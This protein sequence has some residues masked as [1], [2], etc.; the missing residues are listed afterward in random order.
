MEWLMKKV[1]IKTRLVIL[2]GGLVFIV[3][4]LL[5]G[6]IPLSS[7]DLPAMEKNVDMLIE[8]LNGEDWVSLYE[9]ALEHYP[10]SELAHPFRHTYTV[11]VDNE[12]PV[13]FNVGRCTTSEEIL[14]QNY[15]H[16]NVSMYINDNELGTDVVHPISYKLTNGFVCNDY[17]VLLSDWPAGIYVLKSVVTLNEAIND[18]IVDY[19]PGDYITEFTV[20]VEE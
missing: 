4:C 5:P 16:I 7:L 10:A 14:Q 8:T 6:M 1:K 9:L 13:Y 17:G 20:T 18:G 12:L 11:A 19:E 3:S 2:T 15:E